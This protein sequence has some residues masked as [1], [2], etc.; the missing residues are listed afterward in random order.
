MKIFLIEILNAYF[1]L[2]LFLK[3]SFKINKLKN[4]DQYVAY[5]TKQ[6]HI[7]EKGLS[8][9]SPR[10]G[11]GDSKIKELMVATIQ[12]IEK[13]GED[14]LTESI[15]STLN[16]YITFNSEKDFTS[17]LIED[18]RNFIKNKAFD[19]SGGRR[20]ILKKN[21][22]SSIFN[23]ED[24]FKSRASIRDFES[25]KINKDILIKAID[26]AKYSPSVCNRQGWKVHIYDGE[27]IQDLL[28]LQYGAKGFS[29][30][31]NTLAIVTGDRNFFTSLERNQIGIDGGMFSMSLILALQSLELGTCPLNACFT[32]NNEKRVKKLSKIPE[33][34]KII[35]FIAI[36]N[37]KDEF[38]V[39]KSERR[40][41]E[42]FIT[43]H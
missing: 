30:S 24:F 41:N 25:T 13:F 34:E 18:I 36:G 20:K 31:V 3:H 7:I 8:L 14:K 28:S 42:T 33:N 6:Y 10:V 35:M 38:Y 21:M 37:L 4:K 40:S 12:Y 32:F 39:A 17:S 15:V 29:N 2:F 26:I 22:K 43:F 9:P 19:N 1:D 27:I 23:Y 16:D 11:F 5:L